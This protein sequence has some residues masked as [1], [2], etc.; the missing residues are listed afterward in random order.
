M[1]QVSGKL[2]SLVYILF[3]T[4]Y[5]HFLIVVVYVCSRLL[6]FIYYTKQT[7]RYKTK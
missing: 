2:T 1:Q 5:D 3:G 4:D 7:N 6:Y